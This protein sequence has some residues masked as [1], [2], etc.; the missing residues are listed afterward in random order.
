MYWDVYLKYVSD[1]VH[2]ELKQRLQSFSKT[3][4]DSIKQMLHDFNN[5]KNIS[6]GLY[7]FKYY[8]QIDVNIIH[9]IQFERLLRRH[10]LSFFLQKN[11]SIGFFKLLWRIILSY[12]IGIW[13]WFSFFKIMSWIVFN[14]RSKF[15]LQFAKRT[16]KYFIWNF[17][18]NRLAC[19]K[20]ATQ[21][22]DVI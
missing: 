14:R 21:L 13:R 12:S 10:S 19:N 5:C 3:N 4:S 7:W 18:R 8:D 2:F 11:R 9:I 22:S 6:I 20:V 1:F 15:S 17:E 16:R